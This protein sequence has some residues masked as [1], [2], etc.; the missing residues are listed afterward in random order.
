MTFQVRSLCQTDWSRRQKVGKE[1]WGQDKVWCIQR[2]GFISRC[3]ELV[4]KTRGVKPKERQ[5]RREKISQLFKRTQACCLHTSPKANMPMQQVIK[6]LITG[7]KKTFCIVKGL[8]KT[9]SGVLSNIWSP[10]LR[11]NVLARKGVQQTF[12]CLQRR[13]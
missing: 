8:G 6:S 5:I 12:T 13:Y 11:K 2:C 4:T 1:R 9:S 10:Y 7:I 3:V